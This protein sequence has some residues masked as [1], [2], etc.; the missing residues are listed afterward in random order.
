MRRQKLDAIPAL[1]QRDGTRLS[2]PAATSLC[3]DFPLGVER[4][5]KAKTNGLGM[6]G[7]PNTTPIKSS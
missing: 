2:Q 3:A 4:N 5:S 1:F 7:V 6:H